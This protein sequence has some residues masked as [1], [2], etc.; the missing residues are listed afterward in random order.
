MA[1]LEF[2]LGWF[3]NLNAKDKGYLGEVIAGMVLR[4]AL[5]RK[6]EAFFPEFD[7]AP[8]PIFFCKHRVE[9]LTDV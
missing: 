5:N 6:P 1:S 2:G 3:K 4:E 9:P 8:T 7:G